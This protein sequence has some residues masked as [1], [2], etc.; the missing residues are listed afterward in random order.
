V[1]SNWSRRTV[2]L[3]VF[4]L[5][6]VIHTWPLATNPAHLS[7]NDTG[8]AM[9]NE[10][11]IAW[12]AHQL[13]RDPFH[14]FD[15]NIFYPERLTLCYSEAMIVQGILAMPIVALGGS[16]VLAYNLVLMLG[17]ALTGWAFCLLVQH[18]TGSWAAGYVSGSLAAFNA[19]V[20]VRLAHLQTMHVEF[21]ALFLF[22]LD[23]L[24]AS[25]RTRDALL[26]GAAF[27][28]QG[29]TSV[30]LLVFSAWTLLF[31]VLARAG[32]WVK[33]KPVRMAGL[34]AGA[35]VTALVLMAPYLLAYQGLH[36]LT[37]FERT[38]VDARLFAGSW[39]DYLSTGGRL[40]YALW[41][42]R[43]FP[44]SLSPTFPGFVAVALVTL[45]LARRETWSDAR[46]RMCLVVGAGCIAVSMAPNLAI[47][48]ALHRLIPLFRAV[49]VGAHIGQ[50]VLLMVAVLAGFGVAALGRRWGGARGW[51]AVVVA[52]C[53][54]VN[55]EALRAPFKY[56]RFT[57]IAGVY[58][59]LARERRAV[60]V[61]LP[62]YEPRYFFA[63]GPYMLNATRHW[64]P[65]LNG[66][67]GFRPASYNATYEAVRDFPDP[68][69]LAALHDRGVTHVVV[70]ATLFKGMLGPERFDAIGRIASLQPVAEEG[71][72]YVYRLR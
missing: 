67:S 71:D 49:R 62:F 40:H 16:A 43:Y 57:R 52:L 15:A 20:L 14:V 54:L 8:D 10:W 61:E 45:A 12:V 60:I 11:A 6:T 44:Q 46:A 34:L 7:R 27:A 50:I 66:Y 21:I 47:Y 25:R 48:P 68:S 24:I 37:G 19:H 69:S 1:R 31:A 23:R 53:A 9:L 36:Q 38:V 56:E 22:A 72:I 65:I 33:K 42:S 55:A 35:G 41:S 63:S 2:A 17:F 58:D 26:L 13:P 3:A 70:H 4:I 30:Y 39:V 28:L 29:L 59:V 18:W 51:P 32:E 5:L 64:H